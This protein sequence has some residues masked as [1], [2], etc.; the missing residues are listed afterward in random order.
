VFRRLTGVGNNGLGTWDLLTTRTDGTGIRTVVTGNAFR[1]APDWGP[2]GI[3]FAEQDPA[4]NQYSLVVVQPD[5]SGR[6]VV[7]ALPAGFILSYPR[8]LK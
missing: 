4:T 5:G 2:Q 6:H 1:G 8:W 3:L 7:L